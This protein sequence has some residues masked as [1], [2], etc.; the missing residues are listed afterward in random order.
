MV[1]IASSMVVQNISKQSGTLRRTLHDKKH[2]AIAPARALY[3]MRIV[4]DSRRRRVPSASSLFQFSVDAPSSC[5]WR[6]RFSGVLV[7]FMLLK[8][9]A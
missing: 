2:L 1:R 8:T 5:K 6:S 4:I 7:Q 3:L 9:I